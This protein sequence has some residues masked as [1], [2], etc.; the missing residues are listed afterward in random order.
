MDHDVGLPVKQF[1]R[2]VLHRVDDARMRMASAC[3][4][5]TTREIQIPTAMD[6]VQVR[7]IA[8]INVDVED[9]TPHGG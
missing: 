5:D 4:T 2:L 7:T 1:A 6:I 3:D 9:A 8:V